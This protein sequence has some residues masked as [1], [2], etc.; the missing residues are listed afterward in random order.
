MNEGNEYITLLEGLPETSSVAT[1]LKL[2]VWMKS[3][4]INKEDLALACQIFL[5]VNQSIS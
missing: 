2:I 5:L 3:E 1:Y 4:K